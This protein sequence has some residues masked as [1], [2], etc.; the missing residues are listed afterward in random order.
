MFQRQNSVPIFLI[1]F[2]ALV[3]TAAIVVD[4]VGISNPTSFGR[5]QIMLTSIGVVILLAGVGLMLPIGQRYLRGWRVPS[6]VYEQPKQAIHEEPT[7]YLLLA[8]WFGLLTGLVETSFIAF[9]KFYQHKIIFL[10]IHFIWMIPLA[11]TFF[12]AIP[13]LVMLLVARRWPKNVSLRIATFIYAWLSFITLLQMVSRLHF[14]AT[15]LLAAGLASQTSR[16]IAARPNYYYAF[17]HFTTR[18]IRIL[19][20]H[21]RQNPIQENSP[22]PDTS[23]RPSRRQFL[24]SA[25]ATIAG[26]TMGVYGWEKLVEQQALAKLPPASS[27]APN[28]LLIVLDTVRASSLSLYGYNR[29]TTPNLEQWAKTGVLFDRAISTSPWTL[30]SH[31]SMFTGRY[32]HELGAGWLN[33]IDA[34]HPT[35]AEALSRR[36]YVTAGFVANTLYCS[37]EFGLSRGFSHYED[38]PVTVGQT[39]LST[40]LGRK[41]VDDLKIKEFFGTHE[42]FGR[43]SAEQVN[44]DF[45]RWL[46][47]DQNQKPFFAFLNYYD[48]HQPYLPPKN[49]A[50]KFSPKRPWG[51]ARSKEIETLS[52]EE[53]MELKDAYD[54]S[55]AYLDHQLG[56]LFAE[57][58]KRDLLD[59]TLIIVTSD[60]GEQFGEHDLTLHGNSLYLPLLHVPLMILFPSYVPKGEIIRKSVSLRDLPATVADVIGLGDEINFP[61]TS[62][63]RYWDIAST[64][65]KPNDEPLLSEVKKAWAYP[66]WYPAMKGPMKSLVHNEMHYIKNYGD[67]GEELYDLANDPFEEH[68]LILS[69]KSRETIEQFRATIDQMVKTS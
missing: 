22:A 29:P 47:R 3:I 8:I 9:A 31:G 48:A 5:N 14:M 49:F 57:L 52:L 16:I 17:V 27:N 58:Q 38:Y 36:G 59:N 21:W 39:Y 50:L 37:Q 61:G 4:L 26:L 19:G 66:D 51:H 20:R 46:S 41:L 30:P 15:L 35:L 69:K 33:P 13:G 18:P 62:L 12:F 64:G 44:R 53:I 55:I 65:V 6:I 34:I 7:M 40:R 56:L 28:V 67:G 23:F 10:G 43:K 32:P 54:G 24:V 68:N 63:A 2:G 45:L 11:T 25:G 60:H 42:N 1:I